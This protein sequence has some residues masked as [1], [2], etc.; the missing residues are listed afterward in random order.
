MR[1][2][3]VGLT[4]LGLILVA[5]SSEAEPGEACDV[6]GGTVD[7]CEPGTVCGRPWNDAPGLSCIFICSSD[8]QCPRDSECKGVDG[9]SLKGCRIKR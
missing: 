8:D 7:V 5:C 2:V 6:P 3:T 1:S 4:L 9:T